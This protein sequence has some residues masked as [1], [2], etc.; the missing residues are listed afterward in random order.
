MQAEE[1]GKSFLRLKFETDSE[2]WKKALDYSNA[3]QDS[4]LGA[5]EGARR[6]NETFGQNRQRI[7]EL[8]QSIADT[9]PKISALGG[10]IID[11]FETLESI[12]K[13]TQ[14]NIVASADDASKLFAA[15]K[16]L[17]TSVETLTENFTE[18]GVQVS[19]IGPALEDA[20]NSIQNIGLNVK[21][22]MGDV[23]KNMDKLNQFNFSEG[24]NGLAKMASQASMFKFDMGETFQLANKALKPDGAI[25]LASAFQRM[26]VSVG[27]LTD[28]FQLMN[29]SLNDPTGL[30]KSLSRMTERYAEFDEKTK[31]FK[32]NPGGLL[33]M[34]ELADQTGISYKALS[35][36]ALAAANLDR[37]LSQ[38]KPNIKFGTEED[39]ELISNI[40]TMN[41]EGEYVVNVKNEL[42]ADVTT[43][44]SDLNQD[45]F[46][47]LLEEQKTAPKS[48]EEIARS[49]MDTGKV[50]AS[51]LRSIRDS[52]VGG[53]TSA[54][55]I[56]NF[57]ENLQ[58]FEKNIT[59]KIKAEIPE[60]SEIR[61][62]ATK[63]IQEVQDLIAK[64]QSGGVSKDELLKKVEGFEQYFNDLS[65]KAGLGI[66][67]IVSSLNDDR[68][69]M[70]V[71]NS[72][73]KT[74]SSLKNKER[75]GGMGVNNNEVD[76]IFKG[77]TINHNINVSPNVDNDFVNKLFQNP[78]FQ[79]E[80]LNSLVNADPVTKTKIKQALGF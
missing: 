56:R 26:G 17:K 11:V 65:K 77:G 61:T 71:E 37:A 32:I 41:K 40:A 15:Q 33:Q 14:K 19:R 12:S 18:V 79:N 6:L 46:D 24:V 43:K 38:I 34:R 75:T 27:E 2:E 25:E 58:T 67:N 68:K 70:F 55:Q 45:Q 78:T 51:D 8:S 59:E 39:K 57:T 29:M 35:D 9:R 48:L 53:F 10:D 49:S 66:E 73:F 16:I 54:D 1:T 72:P 36:S 42:G 22:V 76:L 28:P 31:T 30:Q 44:L 52:I 7:T 80:F 47:K 5:V 21:Q 20:I 74:T 50:I 4:I 62:E 63:G 64:Y 3:L 60:T 13:G 69:K 23:T